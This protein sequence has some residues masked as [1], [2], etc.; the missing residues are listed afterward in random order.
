MKVLVLGASGATGKLV[1]FQLLQRRIAVKLVVR[2][3]AVLHPLIIE[4][5]LVEIE[6]GNIDSFSQQKVQ[7]L[8]DD[9]DAAICYVYVL[10]DTFPVTVTILVYNSSDL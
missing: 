8:L 1:V 9:C 3:H 6:R 5:P 10:V 4:N 2:E 7:E